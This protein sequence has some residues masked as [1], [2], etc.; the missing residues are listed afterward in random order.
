MKDLRRLGVRQLPRTQITDITD[1]EVVVTVTDRK[2]GHG[3]EERL[4]CDTIVTAVGSVPDD[5]LYQAE[6]RPH[7]GVLYRRR[8]RGGEDH[9][10][11]PS[12]GRLGHAALRTILSIEKRADT[13]PCLPAFAA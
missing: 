12:G 9:R 10:R 13:I 7:S 6:G 3:K 8:Q 11:H 4:P 2:T 5:A 1:R